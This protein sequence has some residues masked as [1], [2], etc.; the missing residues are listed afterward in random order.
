MKFN[1][2]HSNKHLHI[3]NK[4]HT[5]LIELPVELQIAIFGQIMMSL[6]G[7]LTNV[8]NIPNDLIRTIPGKIRISKRFLAN[9]EMMSKFIP[10]KL[11]PYGVFY[12][13][14]TFCMGTDLRIYLPMLY[15]PI[16]N[17]F[18]LEIEICNGDYDEEFTEP[19][20]KKYAKSVSVICLDP[21]SETLISKQIKNCENRVIKWSSFAFK[22]H[23]ALNFCNIKIIRLLDMCLQNEITYLVSTMDHWRS[24]G[25]MENVELIFMDHLQ[26]FVYHALDNV[27][28][29]TMILTPRIT[30]SLDEIKQFESSLALK[31]MYKLII[32]SSDISN[33][34]LCKMVNL[35]WLDICIHVKKKTVSSVTKNILEPM[36]N[37]Q[38]LKY[39]DFK[40]SGISKTWNIDSYL[41]KSLK[42]LK[43]CTYHRWWETIRVPPHLDNLVICKHKYK[44]DLTLNQGK[45]SAENCHPR[46]ITDSKHKLKLIAEPINS[47]NNLW[48]ATDVVQFM[49]IRHVHHFDIN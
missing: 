8:L 6:R 7:Q 44:L 24:I 32:N 1:I 30:A 22:L 47:P 29:K 37:M 4:F 36:K 34:Q 31:Y 27:K 16:E 48:G 46:L 18:N 42:S 35:R 10:P 20:I 15:S 21:V 38:K 12:K 45:I 25:I 39:L 17:N 5:V 13:Y 49:K 33:V 11:E 19:P 3:L 9:K 41:P 26:L 43:Y 2:F 40:T 23:Y 14:K 28:P